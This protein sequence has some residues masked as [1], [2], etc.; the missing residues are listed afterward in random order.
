MGDEVKKKKTKKAK[1]NGD[2]A[3]APAEPA[4]PPKE[5]PAAPPPKR[6]STKK[7]RRA[8][9]SIFSER[10]IAE[11]GEVFNYM[12]VDKDGIIGKNDLR[13]VFDTMGRIADEKELDEMLNESPGSLN[14][15][16]LIQIFS[17]KMAGS[18]DDDDVVVN[19]IKLFDENGKI[20]SEKLRHQLMT[21]GDK[22][23]AN[24]IDDAFDEMSID[25][26]GRIDT[27]HLIAT[28]TSSPADEEEE[29]EE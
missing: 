17:N 14:L 20:D 15:T 26:Q 6:A 21:F 24:E 29:E 23:S 4:P 12:D 1:A 28:L 16:N 13:S 3:A 2:A 19:A 10:K 25:G 8:S 9:G 27:K 7:A 18:A 22:F 5:E 11:F